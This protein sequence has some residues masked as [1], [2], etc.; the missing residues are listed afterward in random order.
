MPRIERDIVVPLNLLDT[1]DLMSNVELRPIWDATII[2]VIKSTDVSNSAVVKLEY[3]AP[4]I[5]GLRWKWEGAYVSYQ[6]PERTA[7]RMMWG[8][9]FRPFKSLVGTWALDDVGASTQVRII[10]NFEARW[11]IPLL[12]I[13]MTLRM[14]RLLRRSLHAL[15]QLTLDNCKVD[16]L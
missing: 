4:L 9:I 13:F 5:F 3:H 7:V 14:N 10:V 11:P 12:D 2:Q 8:S 16:R 1:W 15:R 6:P